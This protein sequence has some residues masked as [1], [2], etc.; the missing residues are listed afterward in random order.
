MSILYP[1]L[2][3]VVPMQAPVIY[4]T[5]RPTGGCQPQRI[6]SPLPLQS[7]QGAALGQS[8]Q[9]CPQ[10]ETE[11]QSNLRAFPCSFQGDKTYGKWGLFSAMRV[12]AS[13]E[14]LLTHTCCVT[15]ANP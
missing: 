2:D 6:P 14:S 1:E 13:P 4:Q 10:G 5:Q 8:L 7:L 11:A 9:L 12:A 3:P 15:S